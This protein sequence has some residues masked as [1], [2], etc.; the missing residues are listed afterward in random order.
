MIVSTHPRTRKRLEGLTGDLDL[1]GISFMEPFGFHDYNNLQMNA[2]AV[3]SDTGTISEESSILGFPAITLREAIE[4]PEA[5][6]EGAMMM[7]GLDAKNL[8]ECLHLLLKTPD[9]SRLPAGYEVTNVA[10]RVVR[11][12][13]STAPRHKA[14]A[15]LR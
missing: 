9:V 15:G 14:W 8:L 7:T 4:R 5:L 1:P 6:D 11:F 12:I 2:K 10:E 3:L 13:L